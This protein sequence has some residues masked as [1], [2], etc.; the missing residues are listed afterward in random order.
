[1]TGITFRLLQQEKFTLATNLLDF[2][3]SVLKK[4]GS[5]QS[6]R[7]LVVNLAQAYKWTG[8]EDEASEIMNAEDWSATG[9]DFQ[10]VKAVLEDDFKQA[11]DVML[12]I[13]CDGIIKKNDYS[14]WPIFREFRKSDEFLTNFK[15]LFG[16]N[17]QQFVVE[18]RNVTITLTEATP[19]LG[20]VEEPVANDTSDD[21]SA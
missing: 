17:F 16:D 5:E 19:I 4:H 15:Q 21:L 14:D 1:M 9:L 13:G 8:K 18:D 2:A 10:L 20:Q 3:T 6:R 12:Q 7:R 11:S